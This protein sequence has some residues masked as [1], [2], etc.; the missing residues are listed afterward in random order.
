[1]VF[2]SNVLHLMLAERLSDEI[3]QGLWAPGQRLPSV[4]E[5]GRSH[6]VSVTTVLAAYRTL[7]DRRLIESRPKKG[8]FVR[9]PASRQTP[10]EAAMSAAEPA[11]GIVPG[12]LDP[13]ALTGMEGRP[14]VVSFGTALCGDA[15]FP[16]EALARAIAS[17]ARR[18]SGLLAAVSFSPGAPRLRESIAS[19]AANWNCH[20][21][22]DEVLVTNGCVEAFGL[23]LQTVARP[24]E[25]VIVESP[26]YYGYLS[27]LAQLGMRP[28][29][30]RFQGREAAAVDEIERLAREQR[31]GA[32]LLATAVSNPSGASLGD[33]TRAALVERLDALAIPLIEDATFSDLHVDAMQRAAKSYDRSGNVLLCSSLSKTL[34]PGLRLGWVSGGRHHRA[35]VELKRTMSIGQP[36]IIQ[37][38]VGQFLHGGGYRHHLRRLRSR[39]RAQVDETLAH[40]RGCVPPGT[41]L[42]EPDGGYLLW[43]GLPPGV[44]A[45]AL[46]RRAYAQGIAVAPGT[47][48]SP[49]RDYDDHLRLNCG[50]PLDER[51]RAALTRLGELIGDAVR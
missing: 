25:A 12:P 11:A 28:L 35:L 31:I 49:D 2:Q 40:L 37:E 5:L 9:G 14:G 1:M 51:R 33:A 13:D 32:C 29:P 16:V 6:A 24:G 17:T 23:C 10:R 15:L 46:A 26:A 34:A 30:V 18:H 36:L 27:T 3:G 48:F 43:M 19:H 39:C 50:Y 20:L 8:Y 38:A 44:S 41:A 21:A 47:L 4:R 45:D 42:R 22:P 7:E